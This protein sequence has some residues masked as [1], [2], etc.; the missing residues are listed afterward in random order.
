MG[1]PGHHRERGGGIGGI[2]HAQPVNGQGSQLCRK[3]DVCKD[4]PPFPMAGD[5][6]RNNLKSMSS[7]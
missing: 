1:R 5:D 3:M 2:V 4:Y 7:L 6:P